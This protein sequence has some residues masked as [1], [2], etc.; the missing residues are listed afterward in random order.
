VL[1]LAALPRIANGTPVAGQSLYREVAV[2]DGAELVGTAVFRGE[3]PNPR[4][5]LVT[6]D[7]EV[8][9]FGY[10]ERTEVTVG[11][12]RGLAGVVVVVEGVQAGKAW[13]AEAQEGHVL[14]Q[15][16]CVFLPHLQVIPKASDM[17]ILNSDPVLHNVHAYE[18]VGAS[19]R[20][21]FNLGQPP[22]KEFIVHALRPRIGNLVRLECDAHDF[23]QGWIYAAD[24]P[25]WA[26]T[27]EDGTFVIE[28]V[29]PGEYSI[30]A[31]HPSL[32]MRQHR[33]SL[34]SGGAA[35]IVLDFTDE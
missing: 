31:W 15:R 1:V 27:G 24:S 25:Y 13:P 18:L 19:W 17:N 32:G 7:E 5:L 29:P 11:E 22:S 21:L 4:R 12:D 3:V 8:C 2:A 30:T 14:D 35:E 10:L 6:K 23:M 33:V 20:S 9:G 16:D 34:A 26:V 28:D